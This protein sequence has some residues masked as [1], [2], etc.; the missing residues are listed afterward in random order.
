MLIAPKSGI[1]PVSLSAVKVE[2]ELF[3]NNIF[4]S[5]SR[6]FSLNKSLVF[7]IFLAFNKAAIFLPF[8][9]IPDAACIK[10]EA[11]FLIKEGSNF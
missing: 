8:I 9:L 6:K 10:L 11:V 1:E 7:K 5:S 2:M 3:F 4:N